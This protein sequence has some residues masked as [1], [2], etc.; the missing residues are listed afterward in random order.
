[1]DTFFSKLALS[2]QRLFRLGRHF[3]F[4]FLC[5]AFMGFIYGFLYVSEHRLQYFAL[6]FLESFLYLPQHILLSYGIIYFILP[7]YIFKG[8]YWQ[9]IA[10]VLLLIVL[11]A[12][13]SPL[14]LNFII[15]PYPIGHECPCRA[16][17]NSLLF[18]NG[19]FKRIHDRCRFCSGH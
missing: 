8:R 5:W 1:M 7:H 17:Q 14:T 10:G 12:F 16:R 11:V 2:D 19:R 6:S 15:N 9:G 3:L 18:T 4:W 13:L